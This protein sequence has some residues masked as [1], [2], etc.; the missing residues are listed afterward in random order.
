MPSNLRRAA[1]LIRSR[2]RTS[3]TRAS[4][5]QTVAI[6]RDRS[7]TS[8]TC[9]MR[10]QECGYPAAIQAHSLPTARPFDIRYHG[11]MGS[12]VLA[13][14]RPEACVNCGE[15][16]E[17]GTRA[18][19]DAT[20]RTVT[21]LPCHE[22]GPSTAE[23]DG[24]SARTIDAGAAGASSQARYEYLHAMRETGIDARFVGSRGSASS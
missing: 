7:I 5:S 1:F 11:R 22:I 4:R 18:W 10:D 16:L 2:I 6:S 12:R 15:G 17:A 14:R 19:W 8:V 3:F 24:C 23:D 9:A 21:C 20:L 13:L